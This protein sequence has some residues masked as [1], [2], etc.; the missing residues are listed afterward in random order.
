MPHDQALGPDPSADQ[1]SAS[2]SGPNHTPTVLQKLAKWGHYK[3]YGNPVQPTRFIP[4]KTPLSVSI[5]QNWT[6]AEEPTYSLTVPQLLKEQQQQGRTVG[7]ILDLSNHDCLY[8]EDL[9]ASGVRYTH[10][11]LVAKMFPEHKSIVKV[12]EIAQAFWAKHPD[13]Y[14]AI[15]C[16]YGFNRTGFVVC[17]YLIEAC[18]MT[19]EQALD[20]FSAARPPGVKH[21]KFRDELRRRYSTPDSG[22]SDAVSY[23]TD[24][25]IDLG[26]SPGPGNPLGES[27]HESRASCGTLYS[28][29]AGVA[30]HLEKQA[31]GRGLPDGRHLNGLQVH[32]VPAEPDSLSPS[33]RGP[34]SPSLSIG[35]RRS[36]QPSLSLGRTQSEVNNESLG[37][38]E[39]E[40][41]QSMATEGS[42]ARHHS[43]LARITSGDEAELQ[44]YASAAQRP[45]APAS[46]ATTP[47]AEI[48]QRMSAEW[49]RG[50]EEAEAARAAAAS[51]SGGPGLPI[52][53]ASD[54]ASVFAN[55][56]ASGDV[57][58]GSRMPF[59]EN[60]RQP[61]VWLEDLQKAKAESLRGDRVKITIADIIDRAND[62]KASGS[63]EPTSPRS[64][65]ACLRLGLEPAE[66]RYRSLES[67]QKENQLEELAQLAFK[68]CET[69]RQE[70]LQSL[71]E[72]RKHV[73]EEEERN[74][75]KNKLAGMAGGGG[76]HKH[77][78]REVTGD[79]VEKE[80]K[81]L[82]VMKR[83]QERELGQM[84]AYEVMRKEMQDRAE[85]K[86]RQMEART[87]EQKRAKAAADE[88]WRKQQ[89]ERELQRLKDEE[90]REKEVKAIEAA[91][92]EKEIKL[93]QQEAE[94]E[95]KRRKQAYLREQERF[96]KAEQA[97]RETDRILKEQQME[98]DRKKADMVRRDVEREVVK[99]R[100]QAEAEKRNTEMRLKAEARITAALESNKSILVKRRDDFDHKQALNE[101]RR[102][103]KEEIRKKEDE[104]KR[105]REVEKEEQRKM[106]YSE[107]QRREE[108]RVSEILRKQ[109]EK[110]DKLNILHEQRERVN[111]RR[112]LEK[113]LNLDVKREKV[114]AMKRR[115]T[116]ERN[117]LLCKIQGE[118]EKAH[119]LLEQRSSL[120]EQRKMANMDAS[121]QRQK[122][123][124]AMEKL[125]TTKNWGAISAPNGGVSIDAMLKPGT[126][127]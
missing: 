69:I 118:T 4:C 115:D 71:L 105:Q 116:Y 9:A 68:H 46:A 20:S 78:P 18:N 86:L 30:E 11:H 54:A 70:R 6:L 56:T 73:I 119:S 37:F 110:D 83:R 93:A 16:A 91:R 55:I 60:A 89:R 1:E 92:Y 52:I 76:G 94:E 39:R 82:E 88:E 50:V 75:G 42:H 108:H 14:V 61:Y 27:S 29:F 117:Q 21:E 59:G 121:F 35:S 13:E 109:H 22:S 87:E 43:S 26:G 123:L 67:F 40:A 72:E 77:N 96:E 49:Q 19:A 85:A 45:A 103:E 44:E 126:A 7:L 81:R 28:D 34:L 98:V 58:S 127:H 65:E 95:K 122:L 80:A 112:A 107:A 100:Q 12:V 101:E 125:Q 63:L 36:L 66:L 90:E 111:Q 31:P 64:V 38:D 23:D 62:P 17:S 15:H 33:S 53:T 10:V 113:K 102:R 8:S 2:T 41:L 24:A 51:G 99:A 3:S 25:D 79:M 48:A 32:E 124:V 47:F 114:E 106:A 97:R 5:L 57:G 84:V 120:Q 104:A 74:G